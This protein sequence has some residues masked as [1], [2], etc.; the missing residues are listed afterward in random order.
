MPGTDI[1][2][3]GTRW[4]T[5]SSLKRACPDPLYDS[6]PVQNHVPPARAWSWLG[7]PIRACAVLTAC[8]LLQTVP[9]R[10]PFHPY[11]RQHRPL[12]PRRLRFFFIFEKEQNKRGGW[13]GGEYS[14]HCMVPKRPHTTSGS[15]CGMGV[16]VQE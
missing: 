14:L 8:M 11:G 16:R 7:R 13:G 12:H 9:G 5:R 4:C 2:R 15:V 10:R 3:A 1:A 6:S